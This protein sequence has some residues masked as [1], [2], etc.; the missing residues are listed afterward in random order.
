MEVL[1]LY[2]LAQAVRFVCF[3][4]VLTKRIREFLYNTIE[5]SIFRKWMNCCFCHG[6]WV[7]ALVGLTFL[8]FDLV[9]IGI[10][11]LNTSLLSLMWSVT[12]VPLII[13]YEEIINEEKPLDIR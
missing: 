8:P 4:F 3:D 9:K 12:F 11:A 6:F 7:G 1:E 10:F 13:K 5:N 2:I